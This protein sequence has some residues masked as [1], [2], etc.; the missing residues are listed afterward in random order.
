MKVK[1][2]IALMMLSSAAQAQYYNPYNDYSQPQNYGGYGQPY[3]YQQPP[4]GVSDYFNQTMQQAR[5]Q[6]QQRLQQANQE[7]Q[8]RQLIQSIEGL[9]R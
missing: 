4:Y 3:S 6:A 8:N 5:E 2:F 1:L 9:R 7:Q